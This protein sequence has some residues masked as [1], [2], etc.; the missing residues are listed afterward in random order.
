MR[1]QAIH[2]VAALVGIL[3]TLATSSSR[4]KDV[5]VDC[6][7]SRPIWTPM[8]CNQPYVTSGI[9]VVC[10]A[11][12]PN[13]VTYTGHIRIA[14]RTN[15]NVLVMGVRVH[16]HGVTP[17]SIMETKPFCTPGE[18]TSNCPHESASNLFE[19]EAMCT[20]SK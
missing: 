1:V 5:Q 9:P 16:D 17:Q 13:N 20:S 6:S 2:V 18:T 8:S 4:A 15:W 10:S 7:T 3:G 11:D 14:R 12:G 19:A